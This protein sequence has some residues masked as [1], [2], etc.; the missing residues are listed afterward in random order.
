MQTE[1]RWRQRFQNFHRSLDE[2]KKAL[3]QEEYSTLER[4]GL[5]QLFEISFELAWKTLKDLLESEGFEV[6]SPKETLRTAFKNQ[7]IEDG[8]MWI[9]ALDSRNLYAHVYDNQQADQST[10][11]I[12]EQYAPLLLKLDTTLEERLE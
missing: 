5:I 6:K 1:L 2:L 7:W 4:A 10:R 3:K 11:L 12:K 9:E 8:A